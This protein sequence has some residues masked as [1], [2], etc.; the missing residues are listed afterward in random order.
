MA[1]PNIWLHTF[2]FF[3]LLYTYFIFLYFILHTTFWKMVSFLFLSC[4]FVHCVSVKSLSISI[5]KRY[6]THKAFLRREKF[7]SVWIG[8][9]WNT[10][11]FHV[12]TGHW[13]NL[14]W[15]YC[16]ILFSLLLFLKEEDEG[17]SSPSSWKNATP[18]C[19]KWTETSPRHLPK[20]K[21]HAFHA[22]TTAEQ[23]GG[24]HGGAS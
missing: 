11:K 8:L 23:Y 15:S 2:L 12:L 4:P 16:F 9:E 21:S 1:S 5:L 7:L 17:S 10:E 14:K 22:G 24:H 13:M 18:Q 19:A 6:A 20:P 3:V